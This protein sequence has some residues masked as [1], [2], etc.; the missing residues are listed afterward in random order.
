MLGVIQEQHAERCLLFA[1]WQEL[2]WPILHDPINSLGCNAVPITVAIDEQG[3]VRSTKPNPDWVKHEFLAAP[4]TGPVGPVEA[5]IRPA[6]RQKLSYAQSSNSADAWQDYGDAIMLWQPEQ[7]TQAVDA[8]RQA[9]QLKASTELH[10]R[11]GVALR[12]RSESIGRKSSDFSAAVTQWKTALRG[13]PNQYIWRRRIQQYGPRLDKPYPFYDWVDEAIAAITARDGVPPTAL[14]IPLS[15][16]ERAHPTTTSGSRNT[17]SESVS[18]PDPENKIHRDFGKLVRIEPTV[19]TSSN[20]QQ[21]GFR[22]HLDFS[23]V[24]D[25][26]WN[27]EAEPLQVWFEDTKHVSPSTRRLLHQPQVLSAESNENRVLDLEFAYDTEAQPTIRGYALYYICE[28]STRQCILRRQ[29]F[30]I[31]IR[32]E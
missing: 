19:V 13:D 14:R 26:S 27:N 15:G 17:Q 10:F 21:L 28:K 32:I 4:Q 18:D 23:L 16:A 31:P 2:D 8:Y 6:L 7:A 3:V 11:L 22:L 29:D 12:H 20:P 30:Q 24:G 1:D 9:I 25:A 5:P